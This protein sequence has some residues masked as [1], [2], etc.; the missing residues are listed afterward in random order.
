MERRNFRPAVQSFAEQFGGALLHFAGR[1][2]G[3]RDGQNPLGPG[4]MANQIGDSKRYHS[5]FARA[6]A[7]QHQER[8]GEGFD[9]LAL[10][11]VERH[12]E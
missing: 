10:S 1:F 6:R 7:G 2:V 12:S 8:S 5:R 4:A 9:G 3:E 11:I